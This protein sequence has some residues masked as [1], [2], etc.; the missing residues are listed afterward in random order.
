MINLY[1]LPGLAFNSPSLS[2]PLIKGYLKE[3]NITTK[4]YDLTQKFFERCVNSNYLK[5]HKSKYYNSLK[6]DEKS[7]IDNIDKSIQWI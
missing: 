1:T 2:V 5:K 7:I 4:Q 6:I 3:N